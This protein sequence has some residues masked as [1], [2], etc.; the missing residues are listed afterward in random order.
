[1]GGQCEDGGLRTLP[2]AGQDLQLCQ[3]LP[4][5]QSTE[6]AS[7]PS[8]GSTPSGGKGFSE[9][10]SHHGRGNPWRRGWCSLTAA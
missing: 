9:R 1:M 5:A 10:I 4:G 7:L 8:Q 3:V 2:E 6:A